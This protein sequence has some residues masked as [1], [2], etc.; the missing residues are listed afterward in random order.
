MVAEG[1]GNVFCPPTAVVLL[2]IQAS[3]S[4]LPCR[5]IV[6]T[7]HRKPCQW[8]AMA[9]CRGA[10]QGVIWAPNRIYYGLYTMETRTEPFQLTASFH[11][12]D[13]D[14]IVPCSNKTKTLPSH[15]CIKRCLDSAVTAETIKSDNNKARSPET[16]TLEHLK[17]GVEYLLQENISTPNEILLLFYSSYGELIAPTWFPCV[18]LEGL[19]RLVQ[20]SAATWDAP[21]L[22]G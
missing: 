11:T 19:V 22:I 2:S 16:K 17:R 12:G 15:G 5:K 21:L 20:W 3:L 6:K 13:C 18:E 8:T 7:G 1:T 10:L 14:F 4:F 9:S